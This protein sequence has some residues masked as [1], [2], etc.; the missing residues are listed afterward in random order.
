MRFHRGHTQRVGRRDGRHL[1]ANFDQNL[2][3]ARPVLFFLEFAALL[4]QLQKVRAIHRK[5]PRSCDNRDEQHQELFAHSI[6]PSLPIRSAELSNTCHRSLSPSTAVPDTE[7][8]LWQSTKLTRYVTRAKL[9][10][11]RL[12]IR[13]P[14]VPQVSP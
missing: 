1:F 8:A 14:R 2:K 4:V 9:C 12:S 7:S 13:L 6:S 5:A 3:H 10:S 11:A